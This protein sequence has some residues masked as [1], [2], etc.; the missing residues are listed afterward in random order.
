MKRFILTEQQLR[1]YIE[2]KKSEKIF[3]DIVEDL[4]KNVKYLNENISRQ[5]ANQSVINGYAQKHLINPRVTEMLVK[6]KIMNETGEII[7]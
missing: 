4:H 1:E 6:H 2:I 3:Y 5:K 7:I